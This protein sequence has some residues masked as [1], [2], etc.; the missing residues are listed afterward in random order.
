MMVVELA[1]KPVWILKR[2]PDLI[3]SLEQDNPQIL[4][5]HSEISEQPE[6][7]RNALR[8]IRPEY[9]VAYG[10]CTHLG[11][12]PSYRPHG[13]ADEEPRPNPAP[14]FFCPCHGGVFDLA[15]RV[16]KGTPPPKNLTVPNHE[17]ISENVIRFYFPS[18][19]EEW[20]S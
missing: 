17:F 2:S 6:Q 20:T 14:Q 1:N 7:A 11:C 19:S 3:R 15:G 18:L 12:S 9:F 5:P 10:I 4:D 16:F 8:S 13:R